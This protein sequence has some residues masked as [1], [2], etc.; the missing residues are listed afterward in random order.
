MGRSKLEDKPPSYVVAG[1]RNKLCSGTEAAFGL[2]SECEEDGR[3]DCAGKLDTDA[4][5]SVIEEDCERPGVRMGLALWLR[6]CVPNRGEACALY[7]GGPNL[8]NW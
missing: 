2:S 6:E 7:V 8:S 4:L 3:S 1:N 5:R